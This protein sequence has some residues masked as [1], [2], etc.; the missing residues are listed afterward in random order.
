VVKTI[1]PERGTC[2]PN[3]PFFTECESLS[4]KGGVSRALAQGDRADAPG[5]PA[6]EEVLKVVEGNRGGQ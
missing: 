6:G 2:A 3:A 4:V 5:Y 1:V